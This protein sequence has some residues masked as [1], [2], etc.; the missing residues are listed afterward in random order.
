MKHLPKEY[1][2][3]TDKT[4]TLIAAL[5][6]RSASMAT[7]KTATEKGFNE[8]IKDQAKQEGTAVVTLAQFDDNS[9][10]SANRFGVFGGNQIGRFGVGGVHTHAE[11]APV[12]EFIYKFQDITSVPKL[13]IE[14][15][16]NTPL[17]D[18]IGEFVTQVGKDLAKMREQDRPDTV[19]LAI[20]TDGE[21][22]VS[23]TWTEE[24]V[25]ALIKQQEDVYKWTFMFLGSN[26]DA[27]ETGARYGF[28]EDMSLTYND[29]APVAVAAAFAATSSNISSVR[30]GFGGGYTANQRAAANSS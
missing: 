4:K 7:S 14:P 16:G 6:D 20:L 9:H 12:P 22:N 28:R 19:I 26:I 10:R 11:I 5:V 2:P 15:R 1:N 27:V 29:D 25:K 8:L 13:K 24:K 30:G 21:E 3:V 18:A 17:L 23:R